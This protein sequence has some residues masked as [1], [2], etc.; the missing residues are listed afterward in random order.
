MS[1]MVISDN[2]CP[3]N[4]E[5]VFRNVG[6]SYLALNLYFPNNNTDV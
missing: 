5:F 4:M 2:F 6:H 3:S 1:K